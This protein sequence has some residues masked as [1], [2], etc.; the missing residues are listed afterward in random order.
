MDKLDE[1]MAWKRQEVAQ[2]TR[3]VTTAELERLGRLQRSGKSFLEALRRP[4]GLSII[5]EIKRR[6]PSAGSIR[7]Q[8][9]AVE[10]GRLYYNAGTDAISVLTDEK[11]FQGHIKDLWEVNDLLSGRPDTPPTLRKDFFVDPIQIVEA[12]E[13]GA[14]A[15][16]IIVRALSDDEMRRLYDAA[17][18]AGLDSLFE[19]HSEPELERALRMSPK[20]VGVNNRDLGR[21]VT[22][23][24]FSEL[25][26]PQIPAD[27]VRISESGIWTREDAER[28]R[29]TGADAV[30]VGEAL[31]KADD[32]EAFIEDIHSVD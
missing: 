29:A 10:Q 6:S 17:T 2:R 19:I 4:H 23:L 11:F 18:T 25:L 26:I 30:L 24:A 1:I 20:I 28:A 15:I 32:A 5:S 22:D 13:A 12:A 31:M 7:E 14:S 16:L 9:D 27:I 3:P 21:F 8:V